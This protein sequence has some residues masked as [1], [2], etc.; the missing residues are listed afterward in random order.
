MKKTFVII[1]GLMLGFTSVFGQ[2]NDVENVVSSV[3]RYYAHVMGTLE[4]MYDNSRKQEAERVSLKQFEDWVRDFES[5]YDILDI[6]Y[7]KNSFDIIQ[8]SLDPACIVDIPEFINDLRGIVIQYYELVF[9]A[10]AI[11]QY[12]LS[13]DTNINVRNIGSL[14]FFP[15]DAEHKL[16]VADLEEYHSDDT[17]PMK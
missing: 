7:I 17:F 14:F 15:S 9:I 11:S 10:G 1:F 5:C 6:P 8:T 4:E 12:N 13:H 16:D 2:D 3:L